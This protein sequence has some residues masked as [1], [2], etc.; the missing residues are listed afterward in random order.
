MLMKLG[1]QK[2]KY[3]EALNKMQQKVDKGLRGVGVFGMEDSKLPFI[4]LMSKP[5]MDWSF[6]TTQIGM[7]AYTGLSEAQVERLTKEFNV[8]MLKSGRIS[9]AGVSS[10]TVQY[11]GT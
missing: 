1:V 11:L 4:S 2:M 9:M 3:Q 7:F 10:G 5:E 8:F 6:I